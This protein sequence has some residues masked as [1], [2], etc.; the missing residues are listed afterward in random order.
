VHSRG[1]V[2][3]AGPLLGKYPALNALLL[4]GRVHAPEVTHC[5][6]QTGVFF[7][8][9]VHACKHVKQ[10]VR[11]GGGAEA[12]VPKQSTID[13]TKTLMKYFM[14][15]FLLVWDLRFQQLLISPP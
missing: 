5:N 4:Y 10:V 2:H 6:K 9:P 7:P 8:W 14:G 13:R 3:A 11:P 1:R 12:G 15:S